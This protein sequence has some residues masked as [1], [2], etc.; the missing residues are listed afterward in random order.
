MNPAAARA[1]VEIFGDIDGSWNPGSWIYSPEARDL[2]SG[3]RGSRPRM[4]RHS[5]ALIAEDRAY[6]RA[7]M[8]STRVL[9]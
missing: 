5:R 8:I 3:V 7:L 2:F 9:P 1:I 4:M 6:F